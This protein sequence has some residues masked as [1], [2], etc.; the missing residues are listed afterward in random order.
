M[1]KI[2]KIIVGVVG[3]MLGGALAY[4]IYTLSKPHKEL[5][6]HVGKRLREFRL[7][8][9]EEI[10]KKNQ[11]KEVYSI[12]VPNHTNPD[13]MKRPNVTHKHIVKNEEEKD[14]SLMEKPVPPSTE[15]VE[16]E[17]ATSSAIQAKDKAPSKVSPQA[18]AAAQ[19]AGKIDLNKA[20]KADLV[21][22]PSI[23]DSK[24]DAI[25]NYREA[26]GSFKSLQELTEVS[27]ISDRIV[28]KLKAY[29]RV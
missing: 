2:W 26:N 18:A 7:Q 3:G 21:D 4:A 19:A 28:E 27:G 17:E 8:Q 29:L 22:L 25:L 16:K 10:P 24:A 23:G 5:D 14:T 11:H 20:V 12:V 15:L 9:L 6:L 13:L 1:K